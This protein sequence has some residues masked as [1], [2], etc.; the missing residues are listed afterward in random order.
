MR[1]LLIEDDDQAISVL[2]SLLESKGYEVASATT[3][4]AGL[5][6][7][8]SRSFQ[9]LITDYWLPDR[10]GAWLLA[11]A[12]AGGFLRGT[13]VLMITAEH[14]PQGVENIRLLR[15]PFD[16]DE[17]LEEVD[18]ALGSV[19]AAAATPEQE[20]PASLVPSSSVVELVLYSAGSAA[21]LR[22]VGNL[23]R[24]LDDYPSDQVRLVILDVAQNRDGA[25]RD[26]VVFT[27]TLVRHSP[28][29]R[30]WVQGDLARGALVHDLLLQ[31]GVAKKA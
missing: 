30:V 31:C 15:K 14:R 22:A 18:A 23:R 17:F 12:A 21:S 20:S 6:L 10:S 13:Q 5:A 1:V 26:R 9:L 27:P 25:A 28:A 24:L 4:S 29:P 7:L 2:T 19:R 3:S 8:R 11:E 16:L